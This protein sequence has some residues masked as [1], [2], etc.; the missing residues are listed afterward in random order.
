MS[1]DLSSGTRQHQGLHAKDLQ[2]LAKKV[3]NVCVRQIF[4]QFLGI[5]AM[6][7]AG[8]SNAAVQKRK[9]KSWMRYSIIEIN[10]TNLL[11]TTLHIVRKCKN[12]TYT[13][14]DSKKR[15][16]KQTQHLQRGYSQRAGSGT[17]QKDWKQTKIGG[18]LC[19]PGRGVHQHELRTVLH[20]QTEQQDTTS[21]FTV[22]RLGNLIEHL[23][24]EL[25][26]QWL[27]KRK[28]SLYEKRHKDHT[29]IRFSDSQILR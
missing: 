28:C 14:G 18:A 27:V 20:S 23:D 21:F 3:P 29:S 13:P 1:R 8:H 26:T 10:Q 15:P 2:A 5:L 25:E 4:Q 6:H 16:V 22:F 24:L 9:V 7:Q 12:Q 11:L 17:G 19:F